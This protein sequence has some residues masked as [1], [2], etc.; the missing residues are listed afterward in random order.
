MALQNLCS[1]VKSKTIVLTN[2][3][4]ARK[5]A[6]CVRIR[7]VRSKR[8]MHTNT[9]LLVKRLFHLTSWRLVN[10]AMTVVMDAIWF[11]LRCYDSRDELYLIPLT[12]RW[13]S[14]LCDRLDWSPRRIRPKDSILSAL[15]SDDM[16]SDW[17]IFV[18]LSSGFRR[19]LLST[20]FC[21]LIIRFLPWN[22]SLMMRNT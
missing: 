18:V 11:V 19:N 8:L 16:T 2:T 15:F 22:V 12:L 6:Y 14:W 13:P 7:L 17:T 10:T 4:F 1:F 3:S 20:Y 21:K 5:V 9:S